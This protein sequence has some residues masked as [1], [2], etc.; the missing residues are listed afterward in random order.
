MIAN[1][2]RRI[3]L[4]QGLLRNVSPPDVENAVDP[5]PDLRPDPGGRVDNP[6]MAEQ[7]APS[8]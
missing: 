6:A 7:H 3:A 1:E 8:A 2:F 4:A 5:A